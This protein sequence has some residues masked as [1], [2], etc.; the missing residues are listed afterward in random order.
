MQSPR[1]AIAPT[2]E[3]RCRLLAL[4]ASTLTAAALALSAC[5]GP[6]KPA[7]A[8]PVEITNDPRVQRGIFDGLPGAMRGDTP[9]GPPVGESP[10]PDGTG[11]SADFGAGGRAGNPMI[12]TKPNGAVVLRSPR[13]VDL[14]AH[15]TREIRTPGPDPAALTAGGSKPVDLLAD[16]VLSRQTEAEF[17]KRSMTRLDAANQLRTFRNDVLMLLERMPAGEG[18][19]GIEVSNSSPGTLKLALKGL[20]ARNLPLTEIYVTLESGPDGSNWRL[21]WVR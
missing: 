16:Q 12:I 13:I 3:R 15:L 21:V 19:I 7:P 14:V 20:A 6:S 1:P 4:I 17:A 10:N 2:T 5:G 11:P 18:S 8:A 9:I